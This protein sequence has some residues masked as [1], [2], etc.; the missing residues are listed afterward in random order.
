MA[1]GGWAGKASSARGPSQRLDD[2]RRPCLISAQAELS[3]RPAGGPPYG[4]LEGGTCLE[5]RR[6]PSIF[7]ALS[8]PL[9]RLLRINWEPFAFLQEW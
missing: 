6:R 8:E 2:A 5:G 3:G 1:E 9:V 7:R 4:I